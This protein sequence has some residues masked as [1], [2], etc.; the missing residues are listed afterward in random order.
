M[1]F[2]ILDKYFNMALCRCKQHPPTRGDYTIAVAPVG[3]EENTSSICGR[4][5]CQIPGLIWL[6]EREAHDFEIGVRIF[7]FASFVTKVRVEDQVI[8]RKNWQL[9]GGAKG[10]RFFQFFILYFSLYSDPFSRSNAASFWVLIP[11][12]KSLISVNQKYCLPRME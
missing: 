3:W 5:G 10:R 4:A 9:P 12:W 1:I 6:K 7:M 8:Y 11:S 2:I